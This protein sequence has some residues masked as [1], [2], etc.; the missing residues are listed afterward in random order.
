M[1]HPI[2]DIWK[3]LISETRKSDASNMRVGPDVNKSNT[4]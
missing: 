3:N 4:L 1:K 2:V